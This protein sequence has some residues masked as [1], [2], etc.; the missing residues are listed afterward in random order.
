ML[1]ATHS[2]ISTRI[3]SCPSTGTPPFSAWWASLHTLQRGLELFN[4][5][6]IL[7]M[8]KL[9]EPPLK[10]HCR[11]LYSASSSSIMSS[12]SSWAPRALCLS[13][14]S[15][16]CSA[17]DHCHLAHHPRVRVETRVWHVCCYRDLARDRKGW[18]QKKGSLVF[19]PTIGLCFIFL[20]ENSALA[21]VVKM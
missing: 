19:L 5:L 15:A 4:P 2:P 7:F 11:Q 3:W 1:I 10:L 8:E 16:L 21:N 14:S 6:S 12:T 20:I 18:N 13:P 17:R 9:V